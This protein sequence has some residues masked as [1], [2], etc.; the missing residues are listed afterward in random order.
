[1]ISAPRPETSH[2]LLDASSHAGASGGKNFAS[3][4]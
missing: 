1:M 4:A 3:F 2:L